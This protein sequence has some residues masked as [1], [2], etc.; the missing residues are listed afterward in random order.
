MANTDIQK[1][2][3]DAQEQRIRPLSTICE[4]DGGV[5]MQVEMPG[6]P[7][8]GI[9]IQVDNDQLRITGKRTEPA[10]QGRY[11]LRERPRGSYFHAFT[12]DETI[13]RSNIEATME[14]G[15]LTLK[16]KLSE[17]AKPRK[18]EVKSK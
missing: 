9:D 3:A 15:V 4:C 8:D 2:E 7:K 16:M 11:I 18:I 10:P 12:L 1:K 17:A 13:D 6:V 14:R 5:Q